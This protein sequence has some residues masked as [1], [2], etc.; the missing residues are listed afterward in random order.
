[1]CGITAWLSWSEGAPVK[2][3]VLA[4]MRDTLAHRGPDGTGLWVAPDATA[5]L[6]FRRLAIIDLNASA[7]QPMTNEDGTLQVVFNGEIYNHRALRREIQE[8][9]CVPLDLR[10]LRH[11]S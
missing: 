6:A 1:M 9:P 4:R 10:S 8:A 11:V 3:D 7:N 2:P 5:G